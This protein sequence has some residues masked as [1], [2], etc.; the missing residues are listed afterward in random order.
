MYHNFL[1]QIVYFRKPLR[2]VRHYPG[3]KLFYFYV[4]VSDPVTDLT[5]LIVFSFYQHIT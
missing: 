3:K 4:I 5:K 2:E 1:N